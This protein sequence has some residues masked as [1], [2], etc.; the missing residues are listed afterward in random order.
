[1]IWKK[2]YRKRNTIMTI[3]QRKKC[4]IIIHTSAA[5]AGA[6]NIVPIPG[7]GAAADM[8]VLTS[9]A[10]ALA[11]LFG[12][13]LSGA[14]AR[15]AAYAALKRLIIKQPAKYAVKE[16][17][18]TIP[19]LGS[20]IAAVVSVGLAEAAGWQLADEFDRKGLYNGSRMLP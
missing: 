13:E 10:I 1:V 9:M 19:I 8:A 11:A 7:V 4:H 17:G 18:K 6:G 20:A 2:S 16:C 14:A 12:Q 3:E 15:G 5:V